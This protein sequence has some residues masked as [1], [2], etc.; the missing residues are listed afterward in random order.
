M[1]QKYFLRN[2]LG[3][4][5]LILSIFFLAE[6]TW[7]QQNIIINMAPIDGIPLR[8]DNAFNY[9]LH[10]N[11]ST[12]AVINGMIKFRGSGMFISY[13][14]HC[15]LKAGFNQLREETSGV[16]WQFSSPALRQLFLNYKT[17][18]EGTY[19]YCVTVTTLTGTKE[20]PNGAFEEC[21]YHRDQDIFLINLI[22]PENNAKLKE[23]NPLLT[24]VANY[25]FSSELTYRIRIAEIKSGQNPATAVLRNQPVFDENN[26]MQNSIVY[27]IY[28]KPLVANQPYAWTVDAYYN[29][30][31]LGSSEVWQFIIPD[32]LPQ[33][34]V[35]NNSF[36]DVK[37]ETGLNKL[38]AVGTM[39]LKYVLNDARRDSLYFELF[40]VGNKKC[41]TP[42]AVLSAVF[43]DNRYELDFKNKCNLKHQGNYT[44]QI[45][46]K[47]KHLY[48]LT[49]QYLNPD[50][51]DK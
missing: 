7:A 15:S 25:S 1:K 27:P 20:N 3:V 4:F 5:S 47:T 6:T 21:L 23:Y 28:A 26:L 12:Q 48:T 16:Q 51:L 43:G 24:W 11:Q 19:E 44:L 13:T 38:T 42:D 33:S 22:D 49:F 32:S 41:A 31:L 39:K 46:T 2:S 35:V 18:P 14:L 40:N 8:P 10:V 34:P 45:R 9:Q 29:G 17:L 37:R 50:F 36:I 30:I